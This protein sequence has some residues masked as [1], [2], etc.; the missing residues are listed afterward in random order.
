MRTLFFLL[1]CFCMLTSALAQTDTVVTNF[2]RLQDVPESELGDKLR[3]QGNK[4]LI[5]GNY[6]IA[7]QF[8]NTALT[9]YEK[10]V[11]SI[12][13]GKTWGNKGSLEKRRNNDKKAYEYFFN[14]LTLFTELG[15]VKNQV[16]VLTNIASLHRKNKDYDKALSFYY[17]G[18]WLLK[19]I[20]EPKLTAS[21]KIGHGNILSTKEFD[22]YDIEKAM[23][24]YLDALSI[25]NR[26][27]DSVGI[28]N[29]YNSI[30]RAFSFQ[31]K[32][33][34]ALA[35]YRKALNLIEVTNNKRNLTTPNLNI[36]IILKK[37]KKFTESLLYFKEG[38][39][40]AIKFENP[41][42]H[43]DFLANF[44]NVY[45]AL[46][47]V[48]SMNLYFEKYKELKDSLYNQKKQH[49]ISELQIIYETEQKEKALLVEQ[50]ANQEMRCYGAMA[51]CVGHFVTFGYWHHYLCQP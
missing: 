8:Y 12:G 6:F 34:S 39:K 37:Q 49:Q 32:Q 31:G 25:Y 2:I 14:A 40:L 24:T 27:N 44:V 11:D 36:G 41:A 47:K 46:H 7:N 29:T 1:L 38:E 15:S 16:V 17:K 35:Y 45:A 26:L 23:K 20:E 43:I 50:K 3:R 10:Y 5:E 22:G 19:K 21:V 18:E 51:Y 9:Y 42:D 48:D 30:G 33:D 13:I 4:Y 28:S